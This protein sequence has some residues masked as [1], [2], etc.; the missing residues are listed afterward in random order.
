[1]F[2]AQITDL[3]LNGLP[4]TAATHNEIQVILNIFIG[5]IAAL[6][7]LFIT[8]GGLRYILSQGDAQGV[9]KA[10]GTILYALVG[11]VIAIVAE[12]IV[13]FVIVGIQ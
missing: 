8:I 2:F 4:K 9:A 10:K 5:I 12:A 7:L 11:L 6:S 3:N 13:A 1:M